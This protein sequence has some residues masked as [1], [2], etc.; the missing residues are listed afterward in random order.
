MANADTRRLL[1][2][3]DSSP[4]IQHYL[5]EAC[6]ELLGIIHYMCVYTCVQAG[7]APSLLRHNGGLAIRSPKYQQTWQY[8]KKLGTEH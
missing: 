6:D 4:D 7:T 2:E 8:F 3:I 1:L 5:K